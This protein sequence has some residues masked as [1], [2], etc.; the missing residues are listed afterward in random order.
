MDVSGRGCRGDLYVLVGGAVTDAVAIV[1]AIYYAIGL[2]LAYGLLAEMIEAGEI[3][4]PEDHGDPINLSATVATLLCL[5][6]ALAWP[7]WAH[8]VAR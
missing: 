1:A 6:M 4:P 2:Y 7:A 3:P 8:R 5:T